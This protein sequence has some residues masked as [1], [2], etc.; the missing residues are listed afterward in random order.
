MPNWVL[1]IVVIGHI[2]SNGNEPMTSATV[3]MATQEACDAVA[4]DLRQ[5]LVGSQFLGGEVADVITRC[6]ATNPGA[7]QRKD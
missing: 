6:E 3:P 2:S 4:A 5:H 7:K 1:L